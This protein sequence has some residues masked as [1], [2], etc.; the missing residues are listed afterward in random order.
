MFI[1]N[2][3]KS[4]AVCGMVRGASEDELSKN[5][6][7]HIFP[8]KTIPRI[9]TEIRHELVALRKNGEVG[10]HRYSYSSASRVF[11]QKK[12]APNI[13]E[14]SAL[15]QSPKTGR[16][17]RP[18]HSSGNGHRLGHKKFCGAACIARA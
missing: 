4:R 6:L 18:Y 15:R 2:A 16:C 12:L 9:M 17:S 7:A 10:E 14:A 1:A 5:L 8:R 11:R 13:L 3:Q